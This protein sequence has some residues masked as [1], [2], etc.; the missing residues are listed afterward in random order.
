MAIKINDKDLSKR[1]ING[2]EVAKVMVNNSQIRPQ[3]IPPL[4]PIPV[5]TWTATFLAWHDFNLAVKT[6]AWDS[7]TNYSDID[8]AIKR[9]VQTWTVPSGVTTWI[10]STQDSEKQII[11]WFDNWILYYSTDAATI[12]LNANAMDMFTNMRELEKIDMRKWDASRSTYLGYMFSYNLKLNELDI[13]GWNTS[14]VTDMSYMFYDCD[15]LTELD[16]SNWD[17]SKVK[18]MNYMFYNCTWLEMLNISNWEFASNPVLEDTAEMFMNCQSLTVLDL[19]NL[20]TRGCRYMSE[21]FYWCS[22]LVTI[23]VMNLFDTSNVISSDSM[24]YW[25][26]SLIWWNGTVYNPNHLDKLYARIDTAQT[27]WYFTSK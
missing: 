23:Y 26:T 15:N 14:N 20:S 10:L 24:F 18:Y 3:E 9:M 6:L 13:A 25:A 16:L 5:W 1:I 4:P 27:P 2:V 17:V 21:M 11:G 8:T 22:H 12:Y 7:P 19:S